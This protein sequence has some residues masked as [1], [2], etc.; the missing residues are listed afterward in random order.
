MRHLFS[1]P[2]VGSVA[3]T[4]LLVLRLVAGFGLCL[5]GYSKITKATSWMGPESWA[6]PILQGLAAVAEFGG[7]LALLFGLLTPLACLGI[8]CVMATAIVSVHLAHG[9]PFVAK[10]GP[11]YEIALMYLAVAFSTMMTGPGVFS[12]DALLF[13]RKL[14]MPSTVERRQTV[15][16]VID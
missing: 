1:P 12:I 5:H 13:K 16:S 7:G 3:S 2:D 8:I 6:P 11:S 14:V 15:S 4:G 10:G 9:H